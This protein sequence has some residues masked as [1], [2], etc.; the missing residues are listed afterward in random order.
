M[1]A[2]LQ[3]RDEGRVAPSERVVLILTAAGIKSAP[4]PFPA[5]IHLE[6]APADI[7]ARMKEAMRA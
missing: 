5:P 4:P 3:M 1:A 7:L 2:L 6:G